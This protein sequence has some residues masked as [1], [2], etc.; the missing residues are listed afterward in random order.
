MHFKELE[1][2]GFKSF[3]T[4]T[5]LKF[6]PGVT[7][8]VGPNGC[9]KSNISDSIRWVLG[10]QSPK[11]LRGSSMQDVIFNGTDRVEPI[12]M[13]EVSLTFSNENR[14]LQID[15]DEVT[16][17]RRLYRSGESEYILNKMPV[18]LK[19][20]S[21]ILRGTGMGTSSYSIIEQGKVDMILSSKPEDRRYIFE[22]ASGITKYKAKKKEAMRRLEQTENNLL[23]INDIVTEVKRQINS[24]ERHA[25]KA[26]K[27][28]ADF[29]IMKEMD[30]KLAARDFGILAAEGGSN[31]EN[32]SSLVIREKELGNECQK[33]SA[34]IDEYRSKM[35]TV[36]QDL[37]SAQEKISEASVFIEKGQHKIELDKERTIELGQTRKESEKILESLKE[38]IQE[39]EN[40]VSGIK[41]RFDHIVK[42]K[43]EKLALSGEKENAAGEA[44]HEIAK[45][46]KEI[47][48]AK[49]K[50]VDLLSGQTKVKNELIKI[51]ADLQTKNAR[52]KRLRIDLVN[53]NQEKETIDADLG[54]TESFLNTSRGEFEDAKKNLFSLKELFSS[55]E[56]AM[57][58]IKQKIADSK[59]EINALNSKEELLREMIERREGFAKS[60]KTVMEEARSGR[61]K[62]IIGLFAE[63]VSHKD[64]YNLALEAALGERAQAIVVTD[65][66]ALSGAL[67]YLKDNN[68]GAAYFVVHSEVQNAYSRPANGFFAKKPVGTLLTEFV[69]IEENYR[70]AA[71]CLLDNVYVAENAEEARAKLESAKTSASFVTKDGEFFK[72]GLCKDGSTGKDESASLIGRAARLHEVKKSKERIFADIE[73]LKEEENKIRAE[74]ESIRQ[75]SAKA[76]K[77]ARQKEIRLANIDSKKQGILENLKKVEDEIA[78]IGLEIDEVKEAVEDISKKGEELNGALNAK[79]TEHNAL[80]DMI[81]SFETH[82]EESTKR[83][84][85]LAIEASEIRSQL[86]LIA[87]NEEVGERDL[88]RAEGALL[89]MREEISLK[90]KSIAEAIEKLETIEAEGLKLCVEIE[91]KEKEKEYFKV[92]LSRASAEKK[93]GQKELSDNEKMFSEKGNLVNELRNKIRNFEIHEKECELKIINLKDRINQAYKIDIQNFSVEFD[94]NTNWE[95]LRNQAEVL[96]IKLDKLGP[97]NLVAIDELKELEERSSFLTEQQQDLLQAKDSLHKAI[98]KINKTTKALFLDAFQKIQIEF[99][100][101]FRMLFN[102]G[103]AEL[104][105]IDEGD[106]L[107]SGIEIVARP[108]GKKLQNLL[109][110][111]GGEKAL[112]AIALLFAIFKVKPSPFCILDE[113]D[114]PLDESNIGRFI[115]I[116]QEFVKMSQF[117]IITHNKKTIHMANVLYGITMQE[118]GVSKVVSVKFGEDT[119]AKKEEILV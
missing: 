117:I 90:Q 97:V 6:E 89:E 56:R 109:L 64:G 75:N 33:I 69:N 26:E 24:I 4:R 19:D 46:Q 28:K 23:R 34:L 8:V 65:R 11:S 55:K 36:L 54:E 83:K 60:V 27:Y 52:L 38:K 37:A 74:I 22:E 92:E 42:L 86:T 44:E 62:G 40:E 80:I 106:V 15:Y 96:K 104:L 16:I 110:L 1:I 29:E 78:V 45:H 25:K 101:Y 61:L 76:E 17:T 9:G 112:T 100:N 95:E 41:N 98:V 63:M 7:A 99:R 43:E 118:K 39:R 73:A 72:K 32:M 57:E 108:P 85:D 18:R 81:S 66:E 51:S 50:T 10:E 102:G 105:L 30:L 68:I 71:D 48:S 31:K 47:K 20:I 87:N 93:D 113:I 21:D 82:I 5:K 67:A 91:K 79:E 53:A 116:L 14:A 58:E 88:K 13:A 115:R 111:S 107:E 94:E 59:S 84:N 77:E 3:P 49:L 12:N 103:H 114:A 119:E 70:S 35:D 2:C